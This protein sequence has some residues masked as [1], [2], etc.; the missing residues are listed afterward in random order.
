M[1][2]SLTLS[3]ECNAL[4]NDFIDAYWCIE[5]VCY[6]TTYIAWELNAYASRDAKYKAMQNVENTLPAGG[7]LFPTY[8]TKLYRWNAQF[9]ISTVFPN[10]IPLSEDEQLT[11]IYNFTKSYTGL[12][13]ED[14]FEN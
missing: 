13:F 9:A 2:L 10:G 4:Y 3:K 5:N 7:A 14:V 12:S 11:A 6:S 8:D 1:G